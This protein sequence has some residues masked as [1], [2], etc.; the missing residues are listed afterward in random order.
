MF[1]L[2]THS[3]QWINATHSA[4]GKVEGAPSRVARFLIITADCFCSSTAYLIFPFQNMLSNSANLFIWFRIFLNFSEIWQS[5]GECGLFK[6]HRNARNDQNTQPQSWNICKFRN[7]LN[8]RLLVNFKLK[9]RFM[10]VCY[11]DANL[12]IGAWHGLHSKRSSLILRILKHLHNAIKLL[13]SRLIAVEL[14]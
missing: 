3:N 4:T 9:T 1:S 13:K 14:T 12:F 10:L 8:I 5:S 6:K 11:K 7:Y 2:A